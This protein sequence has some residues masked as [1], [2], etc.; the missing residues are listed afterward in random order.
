[1]SSTEQPSPEGRTYLVRLNHRG[2]LQDLAA[3]PQQVVERLMTA[4]A[5]GEAQESAI[6]S[7]IKGSQL[8]LYDWTVQ[9]LVDGPL[10]SR[11]DLRVLARLRPI[12]PTLPA[13][14]HAD[15]DVIAEGRGRSQCRWCGRGISVDGRGYAHVLRDGRRGPAT[16]RAA[17]RQWTGSVDT[18]LAPSRSATPLDL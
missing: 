12:D 15:S 14:L 8:E 13:Q 4:V 10:R 6:K 17:S 2:V 1:M 16:C 5:V 3:L 18:G 11:R 9:R 7:G